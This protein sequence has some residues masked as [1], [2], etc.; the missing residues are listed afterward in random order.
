MHTL[1]FQNLNFEHLVQFTESTMTHVHILLQIMG[2]TNP[3]GEEKFIAAAFPSACGKTNMAMMKPSLPG[4]KV[5]KSLYSQ[6]ILYFSHL[7]F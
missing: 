2:V 6:R 1:Y 3:A 7:L 4:W 5:K